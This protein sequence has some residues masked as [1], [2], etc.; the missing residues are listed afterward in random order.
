MNNH[1]RREFLKQGTLASMSIGLL[2][3]GTPG[4]PFM[5]EKESRS[6]IGRLQRK[7]PAHWIWT[8]VP[9]D[10]P[11]KMGQFRL[12]FDWDGKGEIWWL[13]YADSLYTIWCNGRTLGVGPVM[14]VDA[15]PRLSRWDLGGVAEKGNNVLAL[16]VW[17][18]GER[19]DVGDVS[20]LEAGVIGWLFAG[21]QVVATGADWKAQDAKGYMLPYPGNYRPFTE[22][23]LV[24]ADL[25]NEPMDWMEKNFDDNGWPV[26]REVHPFDHPRRKGLRVSP[27]P[28]LTCRELPP[29]RILDA[30]WAKGG[31][32]VE[33]ARDVAVRI[34]EQEHE[35]LL[36]GAIELSYPFNKG[37]GVSIP[38]ATGS[39]QP[40][41]MGWDSLHC[42]VHSPVPNGG[43]EFF[44]TF[45][46]GKQT[47][48]CLLLEISTGQE[49]TLDI[50]YG[51]QLIKGRINPTLQHSLADRV[52]VPAGH[53][54]FRLPHDRG[55]RYVQVNLSA[56]AELKKASWEEHVYPHPEC[57]PFTSSDKALNAIWAAAYTTL[58][59]TSLTFYVDNARR[60]RQAWNGTE[61]INSAR[62]GFALA[63]DLALTRKHLEDSLDDA[64]SMNGLVPA[65]ALGNTPEEWLR[66]FDG[67]DLC[68][69][70]TC[71]EHI[72][73]SDDREFA[74]R[75]VK[76]CRRL[77]EYHGD[78][79]GNGLKPKIGS[80]AWNE[81]NLNTGSQVV[82]S[83]NL[84]LIESLQA[85]V[86][87]Y[88]YLGDETEAEKMEA[89]IRPLQE[90]IFREL[91]D[92][93]RGVLCQGYDRNGKKVP[94]CSQFDNALALSLGVVPEE[95]IARFHDFCSGPSGTWPTNR[96]G[97]QGASIG[98]EVR[99]RPDLMVVAG[100]PHGS[101]VAARA[102]N[103]CESPQAAIDYLRYNFGA[104]VDEGNGTFWEIWPFW[105]ERRHSTSASQGWG[106][107][108]AWYILEYGLG[109]RFAAP[110]G[111]RLEWSPRRVS[112]REMKG[113]VPTKHGQATLGWSDEKL[114]W[115]IPAGVSMQ[116]KL[117]GGSE[118]NVNGPAR[119]RINL[120]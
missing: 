16:Q 69:P 51:D 62:G 12:S 82:T 50:G 4:G 95:K 77:T 2:G 120:Y 68:F 32:S 36:R 109:I 54:A 47:S 33:Y 35:S 116:V 72:L 87:M 106:T 40:R 118:Q 45:D 119:K 13:G 60:E 81:W 58:R 18:H 55:C 111:S 79:L 61:I 86:K 67:H 91:T 46:L 34:R 44:I 11:D 98:E 102:I 3:V 117:P 75:L 112:V 66:A 42:P 7:A 84:L 65:K 48:G 15:Y 115:D 9:V 22:Q 49:C 85:M 74:P 64:E 92:E 24:I 41:R 39:P 56:E 97:Y 31:T 30:G 43:N 26:A 23:R 107:A 94:F 104:M 83:H 27:L 90:A 108:V 71:W 28:N 80:W 6:L 1:S 20:S 99:F 105:R 89:Q 110:G 52:I 76:A 96:S 5:S 57:L 53:H 114:H 63:G 103:K 73:R 59:Q 14:S 70:Q 8:E 21:K 37:K 113:V 19:K 29:P 10:V 88:D 25:R 38:P 17:T 100:T 93:E 78:R 101:M